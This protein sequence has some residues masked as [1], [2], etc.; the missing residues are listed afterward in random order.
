MILMTIKLDSKIAQ[1]LINTKLQVLDEKI[2]V[3]LK[4]WNLETV[5]ELMEGAKSGKIA[6]AEPDAIELQNFVDKR[7]EIGKLT[8]TM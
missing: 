5:V 7:D 6:A 4:K 8:R 3:I 1:D 2:S